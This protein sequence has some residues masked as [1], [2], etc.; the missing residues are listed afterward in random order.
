MLDS[1]D[2]TYFHENGFLHIP[3]VFGTAETQELS[4]ELDRLVA[5]WALTSPGW[6]G[7][8]REIYMDPEVASRSKLTA[9]H[10]LQFYSE[11]WFRGVSN[12]K[13]VEAVSDLIGPNVELHHSTLHIKPPQSGHPFP[14]HQDSPFYPHRQ[15]G[16]VDVL[17]HLDDTNEENGEIRFLAGSHKNGALEHLTAE[18]MYYYLP[19]D[20]YRLGDTLAVPAKAGDVVAFHLWTVHGS[21]INKTKQPRRLVRVGYRNP[22][23]FQVAGQSFGRPSLILRGYRS[24]TEGQELFGSG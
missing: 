10:D 24:R 5:E 9:M 11:T 14:M 23:N 7:N 21:Y 8:W 2:V 15:K 6:E 18:G 20:D 12:P 17:I 19:P 1:K 16:F 4:D 22:L 13:L 3:E